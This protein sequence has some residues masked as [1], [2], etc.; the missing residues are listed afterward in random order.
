[1]VWYY[2]GAR[3]EPSYFEGYPFI[4][5]N[6]KNSRGYD[7]YGLHG[8]ITNPLQ[9]GYVSHGCARM[10][11]NDIV[12]L[13]YLIRDHASTP[14][15]I[16]KETELDA[17]GDAVD[18]GVEPALYAVNAQIAFGASVGPL[19]A[20]GI[21]GFIGDLCENDEEC[22]LFEGASNEYR[23]TSAG[24]CSIPCM[25]ACPDRIGSAPTFCVEDFDGDGM[26]GACVPQ[27]HSINRTCETL[28]MT[29]PW[30]M[31]RFVGNSSATDR[32]TIVCIPEPA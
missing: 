4:R 11:K 28:P 31:E 24:Y 21:P 18:V 9:R 10:A 17:N 3:W 15:T 7:T 6:A 26:S 32:L 8:P 23:C 30:E 5:L 12:E 19:E 22:G 16:Q 27:A 25:G 29:V 1:M 13:F 2:I 14:V 20:P